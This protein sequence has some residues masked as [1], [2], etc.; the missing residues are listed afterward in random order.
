MALEHA[1]AGA[2]RSA[3]AIS[4]AYTDLMLPE[5]PADRPFVYLNMVSSVDGKATVDG[6]E[7]GLG[8]ADDKRMMQELRSHADAVMNGATTLRVSGSSPLV[9]DEALLER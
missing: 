7:R 3:L 4:G 1:A 6:S 8:S 2:M 5:P 9:R